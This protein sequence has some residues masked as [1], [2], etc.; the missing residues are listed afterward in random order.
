MREQISKLVCSFL[1]IDLQQ[2][3]AILE[4]EYAPVSVTVPF[5]SRYDIRL[6]GVIAMKKKDTGMILSAS[7][8]VGIV[9]VLSDYIYLGSSQTIKTLIIGLA[10]LV[11]G[12]IG[13]K[14]FLDK[15][16]NNKKFNN[17]VR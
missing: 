7:V 5:C 15:D 4:E 6:L 1:I 9:A 16:N 11:G 10:G 8:L 2:S 17:R 12:L 14:L 13:A 3:C